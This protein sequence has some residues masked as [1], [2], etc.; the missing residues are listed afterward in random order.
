[1]NAF[2]NQSYP[3]TSRWL[4]W[5]MAIVLA[6]NFALGASVH[7]MSLS[8][9]KLQLLAWHKWA[10]ITLLALVSL[11]LLNRLLLP[12]PKPLPGPDW[13]IRAAAVTHMLMYVLMFAIPISGWLVTSAAGI[14]VV[15]LGLLELPQLMPKNLAVLDSLKETH[16]FLN[17]SL[18]TLVTFHV[19]A[20]LKHHFLDRDST[21]VRMLPRLSKRS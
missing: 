18:L 2:N 20:A 6:G 14:P 13:Q 5:L 12:P 10:G 11:R 1:M 3:L 8:P 4:H 15:Y 16:E 21:L 9:Q 19:L 17:L 7:E